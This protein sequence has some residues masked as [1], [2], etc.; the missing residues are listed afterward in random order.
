MN[1]NFAKISCF[2][3]ILLFTAFL[4]ACE[5]KTAINRQLPDRNINT[6]PEKKPDISEP[7][8]DIEKLAEAI[9]LKFKPSEA[10]WHAKTLGNPDNRVP[11]PTDH[12]LIAVMKFNA[13]DE[14]K[15]VESLKKDPEM[16]IGNTDIKEWFPDDLKALKNE[17]NK[18]IGEKFSADDF[19]RPPYSNGLLL[20]VKDSNYYILNIYSM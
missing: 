11:G 10:V 4:S 2:L 12:Q 5:E 19:L 7:S 17:E 3:L 6:M 1:K 9:N 13:D 18:I 15:F 8:K 20:K 14:Q 16:K